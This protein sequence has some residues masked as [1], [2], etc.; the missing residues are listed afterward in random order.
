LLRAGGCI[1]FGE[2]CSIQTCFGETDRRTFYCP[3]FLRR[4][5]RPP[6]VSPSIID[7]LM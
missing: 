3:R 7:S 1:D 2:L 5:S 4:R 6:P